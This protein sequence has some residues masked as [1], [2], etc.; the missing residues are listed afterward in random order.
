M[1]SLGKAV[2]IFGTKRKLADR[3]GVS[4]MA[5]TKWGQGKVPVVRAIQIEQATKGVVSRIDLRPDIFDHD[6][7]T[8]AIS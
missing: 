7:D 5:I 1:S 6:L 2:E 8:N 3:L 4:A